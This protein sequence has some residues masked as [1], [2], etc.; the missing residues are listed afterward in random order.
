MVTRR[1]ITETNI[2]LFELAVMVIWCG[3]QSEESIFSCYAAAIKYFLS[4]RS[5]EKSYGKKN[6]AKIWKKYTH[7]NN[8]NQNK[9]AANN[10]G[11]RFLIN[12]KCCRSCSNKWNSI[13]MENNS[14]AFCV[15]VKLNYEIVKQYIWYACTIV[16]VYILEHTQMSICSGIVSENGQSNSE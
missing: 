3:I 11:E 2:I 13:I 4:C 6:D 5:R 10:F 16:S 12:P 1:K 8:K 7:T 9:I 15:G 14:L